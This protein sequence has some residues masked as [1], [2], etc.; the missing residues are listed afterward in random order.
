MW[1]SLIDALDRAERHLRD[2]C[3]VEFTYESGRLWILQVRPGRFVGRADS[4][5]RHRPGRRG[6]H[7]TARG[8][9]RVTPQHLEHARTPR[10][11]LSDDDVVSV[12]ASEPAPGSS[13]LDGW[14]PPRTRPCTWA[15]D[16]PVVLVRP[17]TSP[18]D[19]RGLAAACGVVTARGGPASHAAIVARAMGKP[20]VVGAAGLTIDATDGSV[21]AGGRT[22]C[23]GAVITIDGT[24][25]EIVLGRPRT[26]T[27]R[28]RPPPRPAPRVGRRRGGRSVRTRRDPAA[29]RRP[30]GPAQRTG[31]MDEHPPPV[32][33][34]ARRGDPVRRADRHRTTAIG[35]GRGTAGPTSD[36]DRVAL[37]AAAGSAVRTD[38]GHLPAGRR[39]AG[40]SELVDHVPHVH[41]RATTP[42][43]A[44]S[45]PKP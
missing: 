14:R 39:H 44:H 21:R 37:A 27:R 43:R 7:R 45:T 18:L 3:Y 34:A 26:V 30:R 38:R 23:D 31:A 15:S 9:L 35:T 36:T 41:T 1:T 13:P 5:R 11:A 42:R 12:E 22:V 4:A 32:H 33:R 10:I 8:L 24:T 19:M 2:A 17:E 29:A 20:A 28:H 25:G 16:G 40:N 6:S